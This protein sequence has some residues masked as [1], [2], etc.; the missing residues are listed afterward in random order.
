MTRQQREKLRRD[1]NTRRRQ[2]NNLQ[3][4]MQAAKQARGMKK[5]ATA[6][7]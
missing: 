3:E 1:K 7:S 2:R 4:R 6:K 5:Q